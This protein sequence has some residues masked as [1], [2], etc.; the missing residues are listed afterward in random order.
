MFPFKKKNI[1][2]YLKFNY[3]ITKTSIRLEQI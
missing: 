2:E 3:E 1:K